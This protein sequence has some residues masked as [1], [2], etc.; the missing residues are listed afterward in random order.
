MGIDGIRAN[1][2][3]IRDEQGVIE[4]NLRWIESYLQ[5]WEDNL[6]GDNEYNR[7]VFADG[8]DTVLRRIKQ[9]VQNLR[10]S[11]NEMAHD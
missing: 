3:I 6:L 9:R 2:A 5:R 8:I 7:S 4:Q 1:I 11:L 10:N